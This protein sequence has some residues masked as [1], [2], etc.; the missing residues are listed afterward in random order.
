M[1]FSGRLKSATRC[2]RILPNSERHN[3]ENEFIRVHQSRP[4]D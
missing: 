4:G 2:F 1:A 3:T